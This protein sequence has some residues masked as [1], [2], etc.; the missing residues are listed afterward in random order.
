[1]V[2][3]GGYRDGGAA[4]GGGRGWRPLDPSQPEWIPHPPHRS[5]F[6]TLALSLSPTFDL[7]VSL[8]PAL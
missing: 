3:V 5:P 7:S 8:H 6:P 1:M 2:V 4:E